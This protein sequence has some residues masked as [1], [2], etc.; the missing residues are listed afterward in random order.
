MR[1]H[2]EIRPMI[3]SLPMWCFSTRNLPLTGTMQITGADI[4]SGVTSVAGRD[5]ARRR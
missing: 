5:R 2:R 1:E 4:L 3:F